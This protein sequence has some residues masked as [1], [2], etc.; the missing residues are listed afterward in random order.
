MISL[1]PSRRLCTVHVSLTED[2]PHL[3]S[4]APPSDHFYYVTSTRWSHVRETERERRAPNE[5][6]VHPESE[7][8]CEEHQEMYSYTLAL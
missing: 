1:I 6:L 3:T 5:F 2:K 8:F 4:T 7:V